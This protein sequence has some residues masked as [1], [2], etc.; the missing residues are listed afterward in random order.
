MNKQNKKK[1]KGFTLI[2]ILVVVLIIGILAAIAL[3]K[4]Q[5]AVEKSIMQEA[6]VNLKTIAQANDVF[7]LRNGRYANVNEISELDITIPGEIITT[8]GIYKDRIQTKYFVYSPTGMKN[9]TTQS[10]TDKAIANRVPH[11]TAYAIEITRKNELKCSI[12]T[13]YTPSTIQRKLCNKINREG[14]L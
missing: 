8:T 5:T 9:S 2:E 13:Y 12:P 11:N 6:I 3:P 7:F 1:N 10:D 4:Y 14:H